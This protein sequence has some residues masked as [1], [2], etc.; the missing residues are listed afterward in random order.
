V[1]EAAAPARLQAA[2][3]KRAGGRWVLLDLAVSTRTCS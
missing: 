1:I 2:S 3:Y